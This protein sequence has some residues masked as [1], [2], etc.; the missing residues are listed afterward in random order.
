MQQHDQRAEDRQ[1]P[2]RALDDERGDEDGDHAE[3]A[4]ERDAGGAPRFCG[5]GRGTSPMRRRLQL[6]PLTAD[7]RCGR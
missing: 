7:A 6:A 2:E 5:R 1:L 3:Q 4:H